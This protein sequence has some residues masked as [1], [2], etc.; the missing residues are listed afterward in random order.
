MLSYVTSKILLYG[1]KK[2]YQERE[3]L[4]NVCGVSLLTILLGAFSINSLNTTAEKGNSSG[5][6]K[7]A[8]SPNFG[9]LQSAHGDK[10]AVKLK[11]SSQV[12]KVFKRC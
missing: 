11:F 6:V 3:N 1:D 4:I 9:Q 12:N 8:G 5:I 2:L 10:Y 7:V